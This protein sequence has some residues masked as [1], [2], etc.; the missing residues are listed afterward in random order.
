MNVSRFAKAIVLAVL[1]AILLTASTV[2]LV[3]LHTPS[4][5][6]KAYFQTNLYWFIAA[7][8][9]LG[10]GVYLWRDHAKVNREHRPDA[11]MLIAMGVLLVIGW[12][13]MF[14]LFGGL[15]EGHFT[16]S[17]YNAVNVNTL[18]LWALPLPLIVRLIVLS[19][20]I[21]IDEIKKRRI[22]QA[23]TV[24]LVVA[25]LTTTI[26]CGSLKMMRYQEPVKNPT[27]DST[28]G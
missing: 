25:F 23:V 28:E 10:I 26:A 4:L 3:R 17:A 2:M 12:I 1:A 20:S 6:E 24:A 15:T 9:L 18:V 22:V 13:A 19:M 27:S 14:L 8:G 11:G 16:A 7:V 21:G 5:M